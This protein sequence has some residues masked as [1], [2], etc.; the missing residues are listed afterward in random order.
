MPDTLLQPK[1]LKATRN[2]K[3]DFSEKEIEEMSKTVCENI[4]TINELDAEKK[5]K[6]AAFTS[7]IK[8]LEETNSELAHLVNEGHEFRDVAVEI[9]YNYPKD[10]V[11]TLVRMDSNESWEEEM[12]PHEYNLENLPLPGGV[13]SGFND[14]EE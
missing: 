11:K 8:G 13:N 1:I 9:K 2:L 6:A 14:E 4:Q 7:K 3:Y 5:E 12:T 10:G